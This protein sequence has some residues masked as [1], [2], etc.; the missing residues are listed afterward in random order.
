M[1][2]KNI[3]I[4]IVRIL[5]GIIFIISAWSKFFPVEPFEFAIVKTGF[6]G[7]KSSLIVARLIIAI[8][9]A[10][11]I[12]LLSSFKQK[13]T[14]KVVIGILL[15]F[16][17]QLSM[18]IVMNGNSGDCGCFGEFLPM[19][20]LQGIIKNIFLLIAAFIILFYG[21]E[22]IFPFKNFA[23]Y[24]SIAS[25]VLV[26][27]LDPV[28]YDYSQSYLNKPFENFELNLD[29]IYQTQNH[30]KIGIAIED[31]RD[32]KLILAFLSA[33]CSHCKIA[34]KKLA[35]MHQMN[36][37]IPFYF[38]INGDDEDIQN[39]KENTGITDFPSS[40]LNGETFVRLA[41]L[42]LPVIYYFNKGNIE[43]Q[44]DYY[45]LEQ[46]HIEDWLAK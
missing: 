6:V 20:P 27:V 35:V 22:K 28:D 33:S 3:A 4:S 9:F 11:G 1:S 39:F 40:K 14:S 16:T 32:K 8:E 2:K 26:F 21:T 15:L 38:F 41:G 19:T 18:S 34:A 46:Y 42:H 36:P 13:T 12:I 7:W 43:K 37:A 30:E 25:I 24:T 45:T 44:V 29:T 5:L 17:V 23:L 10:L 31:I